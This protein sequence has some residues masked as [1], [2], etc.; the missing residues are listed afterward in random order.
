VKAH[1]VY[2]TDF[3]TTLDWSDVGH[4]TTTGPASKGTIRYCAPEVATSL[5]RRSSADIWS[6]GC[7][8]L[9]MWTKL[10]G[11]SI[12]DLDYHMELHGSGSSLY[13][14]NCSAVN[15]WCD[16]LSSRDSIDAQIPGPWIRSMLQA[17]PEMRISVQ[18]LVEE[19]HHA[20]SDPEIPVIFA[21][22]CCNEE[23]D[24]A[25][26][27]ATSV[28][29]ANIMSSRASTIVFST[30]P[31][32]PMHA[33]ASRNP[34]Y[35]RPLSYP[36]I[37]EMTFDLEDRRSNS[38]PAS[39]S[40]NTTVIAR[41][42]GT[43]P[44]WVDE[45]TSGVALEEMGIA[46]PYEKSKITDRSRRCHPIL[47]PKLNFP[48][49]GDQRTVNEV[50]CEWLSE[51]AE[52]PFWSFTIL[53]GFERHP[54][55]RL[56]HRLGDK[57]TRFHQ[58]LK[59][60]SNRLFAS[61]E[62]ANQEFMRNIVSIMDRMDVPYIVHSL[63]FTCFYPDGILSG[64]GKDSSI[65]RDGSI[66]VDG[67]QALSLLDKSRRKALEWWHDCLTAPRQTWYEKLKSTRVICIQLDQVEFT[68]FRVGC[69]EDRSS[70]ETSSLHRESF[71]ERKNA[72]AKLCVGAS[73]KYLC[74]RSTNPHIRAIVSDPSNDLHNLDQVLEDWKRQH[75]YAEVG[76]ASI[77]FK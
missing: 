29:Q 63:G 32:T 10:C 2:L 64:F 12:S 44:F 70:V 45:D 68:P 47:K 75:R 56:L 14:A 74:Q 69:R 36:V 35:N 59:A 71:F 15:A 46:L 53:T 27:V 28:Y 34:F 9:E 22:L 55:Y 5:P 61:H 48:D 24:V 67:L 41:H 26:T 13:H 18:S 65:G 30:R 21:G 38:S 51:F 33:L 54:G 77:V 72:G 17:D 49:K 50:L 62:P 73:F 3:G 66:E 8:F 16:M 20:S 39:V 23:H 19:I 6:L 37:P 4:S 76:R 1:E 60:L 42:T 52:D 7:V 11:L 57:K 58:A 25:E 40:S 43:N 31:S